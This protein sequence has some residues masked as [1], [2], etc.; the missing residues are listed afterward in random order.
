M[1]IPTVMVTKRLLCPLGGWDI[2]K[3]AP[4]KLD[5]VSKKLVHFLRARYLEDKSCLNGDI[6]YLFNLT[7]EDFRR[8]DEID[9]W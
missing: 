3:D 5:I 7:D 2:G 4:I 1:K 6:E 8:M 9:N